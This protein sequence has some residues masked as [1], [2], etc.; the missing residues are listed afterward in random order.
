[1]GAYPLSITRRSIG[2]F[3]AQGRT[4]TSRTSW[5]HCRA[6]VG[7]LPS[8][9][10]A[11]AQTVASP[12]I[13]A[14]RLRLMIVVPVRQKLPPGRSGPGLRGRN[15]YNRVATANRFSSTSI[16][17]DLDA[18]L[19]RRRWGGRT[20]GCP[21]IGARHVDQRQPDP[22]DLGRD[23]D[24]RPGHERPGNPMLEHGQA[25]NDSFWIAI[26]QRWL[27]DGD[28]MIER[29]RSIQNV[30]TSTPAAISARAGIE[31]RGLAGDASVVTGNGQAPLDHSQVMR[32]RSGLRLE[33]AQVYQRT[34]ATRR[35]PGLDRLERS[36]GRYRASVGERRRDPERL[37]RP[38]E[39]KS[40]EVAT[41]AR[42]WIGSD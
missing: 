34:A 23:G 2:Q 7:C 24:P 1:M 36:N 4:G 8:P 17:D 41:R 6:S 32:E 25:L 35:R 9:S 12:G 26:G 10:S 14:L 42:G 37:G 40:G 18:A 31:Q 28:T 16:L 27:I 20:R 30:A 15:R 5:H 13:S 19:H 3:E 33:H 39:S 11:R 38:D 21:R 29:G 22:L